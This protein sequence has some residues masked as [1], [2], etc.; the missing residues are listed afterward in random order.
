MT[1]ME[2]YGDDVI[3]SVQ[4]KL[5]W[6]VREACVIVQGAAKALSPVDTG[7][8]KGSITI[9]PIN[10]Y[11]GKVG[12]A[13]DPYDIY[14]ETGTRKM[15]AQPYMRPAADNNRKRV[16]DMLGVAIGQAVTAGAKK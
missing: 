4:K 8:L 7:A 13:M 10:D 6:A 1:K 9:E 14:I 16:A 12:P 15:A 2:W 3:R 5:P 11:S